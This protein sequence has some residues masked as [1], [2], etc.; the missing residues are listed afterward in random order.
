M[1]AIGLNL[2]KKIKKKLNSSF[3]KFKEGGE[4]INGK[5]KIKL[6][7]KINKILKEDEE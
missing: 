3:K 6:K 4:E 5:N 2:K 7:L 1:K